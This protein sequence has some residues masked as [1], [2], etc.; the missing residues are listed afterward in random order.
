MNMNILTFTV[1]LIM[2]SLAY[3]N[4]PHKTK[5]EKT[6][7][8]ATSLQ[9]LINGNTRF[10]KHQL[11]HDGDTHKDVVRLSSGQ[12]PH[13]IILSCSDSRVPP[14]VLFDQKLGE[15]FVV[16][17]AGEALGDNAIGSIEYAVE[18]LGSQLLVVMGHTACGAVKAAHGTLS[19]GSAGSPALDSLVKD[20]H[21]RIAAFKDKKPSENFEKES[22]AN[23]E[24][25]SRDLLLRSK[26]LREKVEKGELTIVPSLYDLHTGHVEFKTTK[27]H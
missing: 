12:H 17:T 26:I 20:I 2:T 15:V 10:Q 6:I 24:G 23:T 25:V 9:W 19:G 14:E 1:A 3:A 27:A 18:H 22:W 8:A 11:R 4:D 7:T 13:A 16:R 5:V 21:P